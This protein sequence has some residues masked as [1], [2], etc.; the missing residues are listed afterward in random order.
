MS[1]GNKVLLDERAKHQARDAG[2][3]LRAAPL[4]FFLAV[5]YAGRVKG[6]VKF[7]GLGV[8]DKVE[9]VSQWDRHAAKTFANYRFDA[10][11]LSL[12]SE[13]ENFDWSWINARRDPSVSLE[14]SLALAPVAWRRWVK[15]GTVALPRLRRSVACQSTVDPLQQRPI[16]ESAEARILADV[17]SYY[18]DRNGHSR[19]S[20]KWLPNTSSVGS[21]T[22]TLADGLRPVQ[23]TTE[24][25][26][27]P[28]STSALGSPRRDSSSS[29][30]RNVRSRRT[31]Q[32][33]DTSP[34]PPLASGAG[35]SAS[36]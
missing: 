22:I 16:S 23:G 27:S 3:R 30:R 8:I 13:N 2:T 19:R 32:A 26:S 9:V 4:L 31:R 28:G 15:D 33:A 1:P 35:G 10:V 36:T 6:N 18:G 25:T 21:A 34:E 24:P 11:I 29:A 14:D 5:P 20:L 17:Y 7:Q 12:A